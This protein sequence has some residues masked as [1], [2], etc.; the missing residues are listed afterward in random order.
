MRRLRLAVA[1][2]GLSAAAGAAVAADSGASAPRAAAPTPPATSVKPAPSPL[3]PSADVTFSKFLALVQGVMQAAASAPP[4]QEERAADRAIR[5]MLGGKNAEANA[6]ARD[7][8]MSLPPEDQVRLLS[9]SRSAGE[10]LERGSA[11]AKRDEAVAQ[12]AATERTAIEARKDLA[13]MGFSYYD[14]TQFVDAI[15]R[16]DAIAVGLFVRGRGV[17]L[18]A[19]DAAGDTPLDVAR[20]SGNGEIVSLLARSLQ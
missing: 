5:D 12:T 19:R 14:R 7:V 8:F 3:N 1:V 10:L 4:G 2:A 17:D 11:S 16:G 15:R 13:S 6:L 20:K 18:R 9:I